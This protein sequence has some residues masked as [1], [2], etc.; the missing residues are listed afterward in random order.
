MNIIGIRVFILLIFLTGCMPEQQVRSD[1][2]NESLNSS[3]SSNSTDDNTTTDTVTG[4]FE[5]SVN[6]FQQNGQRTTATLSLASNYQDSYLI[7]GNDVFA[8]L[9]DVSDTYDHNFCLASFFPTVS[10]STS[11]SVLITSA[12][13]R[14]FYSS[15]LNTRE[16][17]LQI[18]PNNETINQN[19]CLTVALTNKL[20][21]VFGTT[22]FAFTIDDVCPDCASGYTSRSLRLFDIFGTERNQALISHLNLNL[23]PAVGSVVVDAPICSSNSNCTG[24]GFNCC[25]DNQCVNHGQV[26]PEVNTSSD[27]YLIALEIL[28]DRPEL[29][30]NFSDLFYVCPLMV[31]TGPDN[32]GDT[33]PDD[34]VQ[35]AADRL[36]LRENLFN[37]LNP[38]VDEISVCSLDFD[39]ADALMSSGPYS[40]SAENDDI[41]F[42]SLNSNLNSNNIVQVDYGNVTLFKEQ[43]LEDDE[44]ISLPSSIVLSGAN[45]SLNQAQVATINAQLPSSASNDTLTLY[46]KIDGS[47][48]KL[49][50]SLARCS[51][52][53]VQGQSS[54]PARPSDHSSGD[55]TFRIPSYADTSFS[56]VVEVSGTRVSSGSDTWS[57]S[58]NSVL[59]DSSDYIIFDNQ[60]VTITYFVS[61]NV[62][63][64][65]ASKEAA[66]S[67]LDDECACDPERDPCNLTPVETEING[68]TRITD[69][70]CVYPDTL[71]DGPLQETVFVSAKSVPHK[72]YDI[73][74]VNFDL[75]SESSSEAQEG[76]AFSYQ[77]GS[78]LRPNNID[79]FV[80]FNEIYGTM[81]VDAASPLPPKVI[82]VEKNTEYDLFADAGAFS[83]CLN[84]GS[85]YYSGLQKLFPNVF[86]TLAGGYTPNFVESRRT[87]NQGKL[88]ADDFRFGRACFVPASMIPWTHQAGSD[89]TTQRRAR[90]DAQHIL[91]AN[92]YNK[93]WYGFDYGALIGS[94]DGVKWFAIGNQRRIKAE[95]NKLYLA[96]NAYFGDLTIN[97]SYQVTISETSA[98]VNSGSL[99][100]HDLDSDG[101]ECQRQ[102]ICE[103][104]EDCIAQLGYDYTCQNVRSLTTQWPTFDANG[105][106]TVGSVEKTLIGLVG[107]SNNEPN[108]CVYRGVGAICEQLPQNTTQETSYL[109]SNKVALH[110]CSP[111]SQCASISD[112]KFNTKIARFAQSPRNQ[113]ASSLVTEDTDTFGLAARI[114]GRPYD[115][116][117]SD[118]IDSD[119]RTT[120]TNNNIEGLCVPGVDVDN[121]TTTQQLNFFSTTEREADKITNVGRTMSSAIGFD[122]YYYSACPATDDDGNYTHFN[123][124]PLDD[125]S[126]QPFAIK[127][128]LS[129][130]ALDLDSLSTRGIFND[131]ESIVKDIGYHKNTCLRAPGAKCFSDFECAPNSFISSKV[132][133]VSSFN[134]EIS[135]AE[136]NFWEEELVCANSQERYQNNSA[137][138]FNPF[139]ETFEHRCCRET[140]KDFTFFSQPHLNPEF[141]LAD[142]SGNPQ[143]PGVHLDIADPQRYSRIHTI[144]DKL[145]SEPEEYPN[146]IVSASQPSSPLTLD[147]DTVAQYKTLHLHNQRMC[148][149]GHWVRKY[150][151]ANGNSGGH[152]QSPTALQSFDISIFR[153]LSWND[154]N[155]P[156]INNFS[157]YTPIPFACTDQDFQTSDCEVRNIT[158]GSSYE[159]L[160]LGWLGKLELLG[161]PQVLI[162]T[163]NTVF[164]PVD[165]DQE[166]IA[167]SLLPIDNTVKD[168]NVDGVANITYNGT[169]Y[170]SAGDIENFEIG[171]GQLKQVFSENEF[172]CCLPTGVEVPGDTTD[173]ACCTGKVAANDQGVNRCCLEDFTDLT[174]YTNRYVSSEGEFNGSQEILD[175]QVDPLTGYIDTEEV[176]KMASSM[177][178]SGQA[179]TG[180]AISNYFIPAVDENTRFPGA[181]TRRFLYNENLDNATEAGGG[182]TKFNAGLKWND[183][184]YC[185]PASF[186]EEGSGSSGSGASE[187]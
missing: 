185:V 31:P 175:S 148:C 65:T 139:Y 67:I 111:N 173:T 83:T 116:Y 128:N 177:C 181:F 37:C 75:G 76:T 69:Y 143:V 7:R 59:F 154:N 57:L 112:A 107:G 62:D 82:N 147:S 48:E 183:H 138:L 86:D 63:S 33:D 74:G 66:Q 186:E 127:N 2:N 58:G 27:N 14:S 21:T 108:R 39:N 155:D 43:L 1:I 114:L 159:K 102:H 51:K 150:S 13:V 35:D 12:R 61:S 158:E 29:I 104:D 22:D 50:T 132:K 95:S 120:L 99:I 156:P 42:T 171:S 119:T 131:D 26:R 23:S 122:D 40:F 90:L 46:Y 71:S 101:A 110:T 15:F 187:Q 130:N 121:A 100:N 94:F 174:V 180:V 30:N 97:N 142:D 152:K 8:F 172:H 78:E 11:N 118:T 77:N 72:F 60:E 157:N 126:H 113:N 123:N 96:V 105:N 17:F 149:T 133:S 109:G 134:G 25:L 165:D 47:C 115:Y 160:Y 5:E 88:P 162:E 124:V 106:E 168:V 145:V 81:N 64:L 129:T 91:F 45:D 167:A 136:E 18:E 92:G 179:A 70:A 170:Y 125:S 163:N 164:K 80:G 161:I 24:I 169:Q 52:T 38:V 36:K 55:Q 182:V 135:E 6:F 53:Y 4:Q 54:T 89:V 68:V 32:D 146:L 98:V 56:V 3:D 137:I 141:R 44:V 20:E 93:D 16:L 144:Y 151:D 34:P 79:T 49:G 9:S 87:T 103:T 28:E 178:C 84:C 85:D 153:A 166:D 10:G 41:N 140:D 19:D 117:G 176:L 184:V 73:N